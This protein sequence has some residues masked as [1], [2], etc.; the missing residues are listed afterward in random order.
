MILPVEDAIAPANT[1]YQMTNW[2]LAVKGLKDVITMFI[3]VFF[4]F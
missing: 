1:P 3:L 2:S 4:L